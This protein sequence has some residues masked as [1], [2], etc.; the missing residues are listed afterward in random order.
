MSA[1]GCGF[2]PRPHL[3]ALSIHFNKG[4][5]PVGRGL[6]RFFT[7]HTFSKVILCIPGMDSSM[8]V[9]VLCRFGNLSPDT[10]KIRQQRSMAKFAMPVHLPDQASSTT[11]AGMVSRNQSQRP[12]PV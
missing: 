1:S 4:N 3:H 2:V 6:A 11:K 12:N 9:S 7:A 8:D 10:N 5:I